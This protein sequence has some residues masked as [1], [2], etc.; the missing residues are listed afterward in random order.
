MNT[1]EWFRERIYKLEETSHD[2]RDKKAAR[3]KAEEEV[4]TQYKKIP[5]GL[6]YKE[7]RPTYE[8]QLPQIADKPLVEKQLEIDITPLLKKLI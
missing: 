8:D 3:E 5:I 6:F 7:E 2:P 4:L 1:Y